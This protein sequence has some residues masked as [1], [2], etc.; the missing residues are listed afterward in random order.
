MKRVV[1]LTM[2]LVFALSSVGMCAVPDPGAGIADIQM[3]YN[4][5]RLNKTAGDNDLGQ[6][7]LNEFYGSAGLGFGYGVF[8]NRATAG[9]TSYTDFGVKSTMLIPN[10]ALMVGQRRMAANDQDNSSLFFGASAKQQLVGGVA[11]YGTYQKGTKFTDEV[12]GLTYAIS[13]N[14]QLNL[15][16]KLYDDQNGATF[17]GAGGGIN[18]RF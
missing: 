16:W 10:I 13:P 9:S 12:I 15:S 14:S 6:N 17:K 1:L 4:Y 3:G 11:V 2:V 7:G 8:A 5:Y 18:F